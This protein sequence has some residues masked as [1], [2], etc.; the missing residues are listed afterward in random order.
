MI[1]APDAFPRKPIGTYLP[2][3]WADD[4]QAGSDSRRPDRAIVG[5]EVAHQGSPM[6][7]TVRRSNRA[8]R[9]PAH[10]FHEDTNF[11]EAKEGINRTCRLM[12]GF[13]WHPSG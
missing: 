9:F 4:G 6:L 8:C 1:R 13:S 5:S 2:L 11:R 10:G 7:A 3:L 12:N